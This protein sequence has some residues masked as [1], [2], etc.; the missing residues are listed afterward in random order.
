ME[1]ES[2]QP[3][4]VSIQYK[5]NSLGQAITE[6]KDTVKQIYGDNNDGEEKS[7]LAIEPPPMSLLDFL[8]TTADSLAALED[9]VRTVHEKL[10]TALF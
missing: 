7:P 10:R 4:H 2:R 3:K 8:N 6:L 9:Q 5:I 1:N